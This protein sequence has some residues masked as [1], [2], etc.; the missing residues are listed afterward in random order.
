MKLCECGSRSDHTAAAWHSNYGLELEMGEAEASQG[1]FEN[2]SVLLSDVVLAWSCS[3][4]CR[5]A[6][7]SCR[8][9]I[10]GCGTSEHLWL[11]AH[12]ASHCTVVV[13]YFFCE[14]YGCA[15]SCCRQAVTGRQ[16]TN[17]NFAAGHYG[18]E[19]QCA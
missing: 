11:Q 13:A 4:H 14:P 6:W 18:L 1:C 15:V 19:V 5:T 12:A 8:A 17:I 7:S 16:N 9:R 2:R 10:F 3:C